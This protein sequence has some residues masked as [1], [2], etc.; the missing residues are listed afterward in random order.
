MSRS[1]IFKFNKQITSC[2]DSIAVMSSALCARL[3]YEAGFESLFRNFSYIIFGKIK[4]LLKGA[5]DKILINFTLL[6]IIS[7][8][9]NSAKFRGGGVAEGQPRFDKGGLQ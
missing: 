9:P 4:Q 8:A 1:I 5:K 7:G 6:I 2:S 3:L